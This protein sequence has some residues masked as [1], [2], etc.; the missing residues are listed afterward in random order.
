MQQVIRA[1]DLILGIWPLFLDEGEKVEAGA[2][3]AIH[4]YRRMRTRFEV[5]ENRKRA[6]V[7]KMVPEALE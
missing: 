6:N 1:L 7:D 3:S 2:K 5:Q 4:V